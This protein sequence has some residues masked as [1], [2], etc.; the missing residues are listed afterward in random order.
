MK[1]FLQ[2]GHMK[3]ITKIDMRSYPK[4]HCEETIEFNIKNYPIIDEKLFKKIEIPEETVPIWFYWHQGISNAP[5]IVKLCYKTLQ[6][7]IIATNAKII[8]LDKNNL[9]EYI[10]LPKYV[11]EKVNTNYTHLSDIIRTGLL[12]LYGGFW[13]DATY[14]VLKPIDNDFF[15]QNY[16]TISAIQE[17]GMAINYNKYHLNC[18]LIHSNNKLMY[19]TYN[20]ACHYWRYNDNLDS[21]DYALVD[22]IINFFYRNDEECRQLLDSVEANNP[23]LYAFKDNVELN[24]ELNNDFL[25]LALENTTFFKT[26]Y[27]KE[28]FNKNNSYYGYFWQKYM[29]DK[30][31]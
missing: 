21:K 9:K 11:I 17:T 31:E 22:A 12:Y 27:K 24:K 25:N 29:E 28:P 5:D 18:F 16:W 15:N 2:T 14:L 30:N 8:L 19:N 1:G 13:I 4:R 23:M 20:I 10:D 26:T 6:K 3:K 7:N